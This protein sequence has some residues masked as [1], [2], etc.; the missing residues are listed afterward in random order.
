MAVGRHQEGV[1]PVALVHPVQQGH[2]LGGRGALVEH[3]GVGQVHAGEVEY[4]L[5]EGEQ[6][7]QSA[8]GDFRLVRGVG[9]VPARV[10]QHVALDHGRCPGVVVAGTDIGLVDHV[11]CSQRA[12]P[13]QHCLF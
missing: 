10:F 3:G 5:L 2:G 7:L 13:G 12:Q 4:H 6:R 9:G 1:A 8:L 11:L